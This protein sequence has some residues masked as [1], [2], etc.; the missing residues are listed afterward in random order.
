MFALVA[1][2]VVSPKNA[3][4]YFD[5]LKKAPEFEQLLN[6]KIKVCDQNDPSVHF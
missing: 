3:R 5:K 4:R 2:S 6:S 1:D